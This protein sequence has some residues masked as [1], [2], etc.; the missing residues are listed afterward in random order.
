[1]AC[2]KK[3]KQ[4]KKFKEKTSAVHLTDPNRQIEM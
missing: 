1:M 3:K 4:K 2:K